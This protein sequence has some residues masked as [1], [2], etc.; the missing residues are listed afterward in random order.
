MINLELSKQAV[1][2]L[3][4]ASPENA[5]TLAA[6]FYVDAQYLAL[7]QESIFENSWQLVGHADQ[8]KNTGDQNGWPS[9]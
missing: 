1:A 6:D 5:S 9:R 4:D 3:Q 7:E 8:L 2:T